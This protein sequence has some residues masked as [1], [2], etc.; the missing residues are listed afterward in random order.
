MIDRRKTE[1]LVEEKLSGTDH[2]LVAVLIKPGNK[3]LVFIDSDTHV[4]ID[5]CVAVSRHIEANLDREVEDYELQVSSAGLDQPFK[6]LRQYH[7]NTGKQVDIV[8]ND[9]KK[10]TG[11][12]ARVENSGVELILKPAGKEISEKKAFIGFSEIKETKIKI[13]F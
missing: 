8:L 4:T 12:L 11:I 6:L 2:F 13:I 9:G 5:D 10:I 7:K 3:I 1:H